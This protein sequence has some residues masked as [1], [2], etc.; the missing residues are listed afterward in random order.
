MNRIIL[1]VQLS[2]EKMMRLTIVYMDDRFISKNTSDLQ[3]FHTQDYNFCIYTRD[4]LAIVDSG[5]VRFPDK[6]NYK[7]GMHVDHTFASND[8]RKAYLWELNKCLHEWSNDYVP[9]VKGSDYK[10]RKQ[11]M[12]LN[13]EFWIL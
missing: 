6:K 1:K 5:S 8:E 7:A 12:E 2:G 3:Y 13:G 4:T 11:K 10:T 9:F